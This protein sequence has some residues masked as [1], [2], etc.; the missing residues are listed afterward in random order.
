MTYRAL[1][2]DGITSGE[3][4]G[5][6]DKDAATAKLEIETSSPMSDYD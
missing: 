4:P 6:I 5:R 1:R 3:A 2:L